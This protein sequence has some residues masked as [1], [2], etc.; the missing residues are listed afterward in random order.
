MEY[1][2][3]LQEGSLIPADRVDS[4]ELFTVH[5]VIMT[6]DTPVAVAHHV[7]VLGFAGRGIDH[8]IA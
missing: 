3:S 2:Y 7:Y 4:I 6:Q 5:S 1:L 8:P